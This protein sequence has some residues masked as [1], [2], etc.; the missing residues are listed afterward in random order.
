MP[1]FNNK[2]T[3]YTGSCREHAEGSIFTTYL[4]RFPKGSWWSPFLKLTC[5]DS[6]S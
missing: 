1:S 4:V 2:L 6:W 3:Y 5:L